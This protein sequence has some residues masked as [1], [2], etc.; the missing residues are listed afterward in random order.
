MI[1]FSISEMPDRV[2]WGCLTSGM[3]LPHI[4]QAWMMPKE[5]DKAIHN[6]IKPGPIDRTRP[7]RTRSMVDL[8]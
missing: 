3:D 1:D 7:H 4:E 8:E 5:M 2:G 6:N